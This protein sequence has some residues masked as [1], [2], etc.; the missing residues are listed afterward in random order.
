MLC[1]G[2]ILTSSMA[3]TNVGSRARSSA[4][5]LLGRPCDGGRVWSEALGTACWELL[6]ELVRAA[7][8]AGEPQSNSGRGSCWGRGR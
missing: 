1:S 6:G 5:T 4:R 7:V 8:V 3:T 2:K